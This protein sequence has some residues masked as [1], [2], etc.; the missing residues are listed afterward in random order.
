[1]WNYKQKNNSS[2]DDIDTVTTATPKGS[3]EAKIDK[4][5]LINGNKY[6]VYLEINHSFDYNYHWT[7]DNSG[8]NGQPSLIYH[9]QFIA[10]EPRH[11]ALVPTGHGSVDGSDGGITNELENF[12]SALDIVREVYVL[13]EGV[14]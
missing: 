5:L 6:N 2:F 8:V 11:K 1:V 3:V 4:N 14:D 10:G 12:T 13:G 9:T 7:K